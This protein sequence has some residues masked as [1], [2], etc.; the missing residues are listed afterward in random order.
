MP[1]PTH[2]GP[3]WLALGGEPMRRRVALAGALALWL[4]ASATPAVAAAPVASTRE[5]QR[6][7]ML[8][9][10]NGNLGLVR[11]VREVRLPGGTPEVQFVDVAAQI[12]PTSVHLR[13]LSDPAS[14]KI[15]EQNYEYD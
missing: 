8:T 11:D 2:T 7:M 10:Y 15:L 6:D 13:S 14:L 12:D 9:I 4:S 5:D 3:H 1:D